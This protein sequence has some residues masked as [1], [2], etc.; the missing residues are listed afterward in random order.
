MWE[1]V[2]CRM[3]RW[4]WHHQIKAELDFIKY[5]YRTCFLISVWFPSLSLAYIL[6]PTLPHCMCVLVYF[7][8]ASCSLSFEKQIF[9][10]LSVYSHRELFRDE[11]LNVF[12]PRKNQQS[13]YFCLKNKQNVCDMKLNFSRENAEI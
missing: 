1:Y 7:L 4:W 12:I 9:F 5:S 8:C 2:N 11:F 3:R 6:S 13:K 10:P